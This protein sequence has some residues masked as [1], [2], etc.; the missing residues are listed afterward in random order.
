MN[1]NHLYYFWILAREGSF[2]RAAQVLSI[3][4]SAVSEQIRLLEHQL[5]L[6]LFD[7]S[8]KRRIRLTEDGK[9][10][11]EYADTIF[12]TGQE[13]LRWARG[14]SAQGDTLLRIGAVSGLSRYFQYEFLKPLVGKPGIRIEVA[15]GDY[16]KMLPLLREHSIDLILAS[17]TVPQ[18]ADYGFYAHVLTESPLWF[19]VA[20]ELKRRD[21][22]LKDY[23]KS[24]QLAL[25]S[26]ALETRPE[27][28]AYLERHGLK[29]QISA[30]LDDVALLRLFALHSGNVVIA[31]ELGVINDLRAKQLVAI[32][33]LDVV[34]KYYA[35]TRQKK[36]PNDLAAS[37]ISEM[38]TG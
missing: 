21:A 27:I 13:M 19:F 30:E 35:I 36:F 12:E 37:L 24:H 18:E 34:Q 16:Q 17:S 25:P 38:K 32:K 10:I 31:P 28:D 20:T 22:S 4:Q 14:A 3:S 33:K 15:T 11:F 23:L 1:Y 2:T 8:N 7:R 6:E 29:F 5:E 9:K 26:R